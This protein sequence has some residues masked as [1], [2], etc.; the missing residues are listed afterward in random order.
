[1]RKFRVVEVRWSP[2]RYQNVCS[3]CG[4]TT[5]SLYIATGH[6]HTDERADLC[7]CGAGVPF[8]EFFAKVKNPSH[9]IDYYRV[10]GVEL[11]PNSRV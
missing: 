8:Y 2:R 4:R 11:K 6:D 10:Y 5:H 1:M 7:S 9:P 3:S